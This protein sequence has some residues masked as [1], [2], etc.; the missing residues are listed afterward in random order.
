MNA[1]MGS[2]ISYSYMVSYTT[3]RLPMD[4]EHAIKPLDAQV[5]CDVIFRKADRGIKTIERSHRHEYLQ[6]EYE[7]KRDSDCQ[8]L[9]LQF[10]GS[11]KGASPSV[12]R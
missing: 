10:L 3:G 12:A 6:R 2:E 9:G 8:R 7:F 11:I 4:L 5:P 1:I